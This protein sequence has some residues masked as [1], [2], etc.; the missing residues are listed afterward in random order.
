[1]PRG[2]ARQWR[3]V[4]RTAAAHRQ[5]LCLAGAGLLL[6]AVSSLSM[7]PG[8]PSVSRA[9]GA[10][11]AMALLWVT[12]PIPVSVT[13]MLPLVLFPALGI[14]SGR[15]TAVCYMSD[16]HFVFIGSFFLANAVEKV[17]LHRRIA[18]ALMG[19]LGIKPFWLLFGFCSASFLL[20]TC[21]SNTATAI[22]VIPLAFAVLDR[23]EA[24]QGETAAAAAAA[25]TAAATP[26]DGPSREHAQTQAAGT[27]AKERRQ[28]A[29]VVGGADGRRDSGAEADIRRAEALADARAPAA[30]PA[31]ADGGTRA[32]AEQEGGGGGR[33]VAEARRDAGMGLLRKG[34]ALGV[35]Y[36]AN[37]G[38]CCTLTGTY[39]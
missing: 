32:P 8:R 1:M 19:V 34:V 36:S 4:C 27:G 3:R 12:T 16:T 13:A 25:A 20:S 5:A 31:D 35:A 28:A 10:A 14:M 37:L 26:Q 11:V 29:G 7:E 6:V 23:V 22:M 9:M 33:C 18:L 21:L 17:L 2:L 38:G 15:E 39:Q 24:S 30:E